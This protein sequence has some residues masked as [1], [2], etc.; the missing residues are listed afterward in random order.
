MPEQNG[1]DLLRRDESAVGVHGADAVAIS[2]GG[3]TGVIAAAAN[4]LSQG[5]DMGFDRFGI[6]SAEKRIVCAANLVASHA[7][8]AHQ[9]NQQAPRSEER[10]VGKE[11]K[12]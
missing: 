2:I 5:R 7:M 1:E 12:A 10:R 9:R 6:D 11:C 4:G 3:K 8:A